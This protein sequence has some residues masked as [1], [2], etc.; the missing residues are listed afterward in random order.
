M[1]V[2]YLDCLLVLTLTQNLDKQAH[3]AVHKVSGA[4]RR[5]A[6]LVAA[7]LAG[8]FIGLADVF[9][10]TAAGPLSMAGSP[11]SSL[12]SGGVFGIGLILVM[13]AG[14]ELATSAMMILPVGLA[15][16]TVGA[17]EAG[18]TFLLMVLGNLAGSVALA[19]LV[20]ASGILSPSSAGGQFLAHLVEHKAAK[21]TGE[22]FFCGVLCNVLV[23]LAIWTVGRVRSEM[24]AALVM[25]WCMAA[26]VCSGFE[27]VVANMT[28][29]SLGIFHGVAGADAGEAARNLVTVGCGNIVGG[30]IF[31]GAAYLCA[32]R[33]ES[34]S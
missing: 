3:A 18:M 9:M 24:A 7:M 2:R 11:W 28:T 22:L 17:G 21:T 19:G 30:A 5:S 14:G 12:I 31:V 15:R 23:C 33:T 4:R 6:Y 16:R 20:W 25:A 26:F 1:R 29:L 32:A 8:A 13:F 10:M 34:E 27:H